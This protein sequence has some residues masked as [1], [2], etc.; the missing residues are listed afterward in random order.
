VDRCDVVVVGAGIAGASV[1]WAIAERQRVVLVEREARPGH[2]ATGRSASVLSETVGHPVVCSLAAASRGFLASPPPG[3][4]DHP[5]LAPRGL[6]WIGTAAHGDELDRVAEQARAVAPTVDRL[7]ELGVRA[8]VP[9]LRPE[10][11]AAGG[12]HEPDAMAID[13]DALL[14][15]FLRGVRARGGEVV[16]SSEVVQAGPAG[17]GWEVRANGRRLTCGAVVDA[18]G[19]W[20]DVVARRA[21]VRQLGLSPLRRTAALVRAPDSVRSW[22]LVMDVGARFYC[23]PEPGGLLVSPADETPSEPCDAS[24]EELDVALALERM[25]EATTIAPR[26]VRRAWA[27]LRTFSPDRAPVAGED[28]EA[29]G[30][31]WLVGQGGA[32]IKT[33]PAL[34]RVTAALV[35]GEPVPPDITARGVTAESLSPARFR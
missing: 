9:E 2:H 29:R 21:G 12:V 20:G 18:A 27:G 26:S 6:L 33:S 13:V 25:A 1:A 11:T 17:T 14:Q 31:F 3:F 23:E 16:V 32:G 24:A 5:L 8:R 4:V 19:A 10:W 15:G 22:P 28:P 30:F 34:A 35:A 7:D